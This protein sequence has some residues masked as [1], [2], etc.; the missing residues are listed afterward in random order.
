MGILHIAKNA[1]TNIKEGGG[2]VKE[3]MV[4]VDLYQK[5]IKNALSVG[6]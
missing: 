4:K 6:K 2:G 5:H 1:I 3:S